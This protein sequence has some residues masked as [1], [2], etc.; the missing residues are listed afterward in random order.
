MPQQVLAAPS[1]G[2]L[3]NV[4]SKCF[5]FRTVDFGLSAK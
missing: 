5:H 4:S 2:S 3:E 1:P